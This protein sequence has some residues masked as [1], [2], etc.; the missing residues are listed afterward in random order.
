[1]SLRATRGTDEELDLDEFQFR[2]LENTLIE[3]G[4]AALVTSMFNPVN[5]ISSDQ[6]YN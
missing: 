4:N 1:M 3:I 2:W 5:W 6:I